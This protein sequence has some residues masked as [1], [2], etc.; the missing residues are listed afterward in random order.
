LCIVL[1]IIIALS[2][3]EPWQAIGIG[4]LTLGSILISR[5]AFMII[6]RRRQA[7]F[8]DFFWF[9]ALLNLACFIL[10]TST[11][12]N[13][14]PLYAIINLAKPA[15]TLGTD[16]II[17]IIVSQLINFAVVAL[18]LFSPVKYEGETPN[19]HKKTYP[20]RRDNQP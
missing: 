19:N 8:W 10:F 9:Q 7:K 1:S 20:A 6:E 4:L 13:W 14:T 2:G 5:F 15:A 17:A 16:T 18:A 3:L 12:R 11:I